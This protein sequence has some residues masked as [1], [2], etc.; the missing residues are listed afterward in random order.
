MPNSKASMTQTARTHHTTLSPQY[1]PRKMFERVCD[2]TEE[3]TEQHRK[4]DY[5]L[6]DE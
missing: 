2:I 6:E 4:D 5:D 1:K 3:Q